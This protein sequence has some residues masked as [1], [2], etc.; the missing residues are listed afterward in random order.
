[1]QLQFFNFLVHTFTSIKIHTCPCLPHT[2]NCSKLRTQAV[3][4]TSKIMS[5][6]SHLHTYTPFYPHCHYCIIQLIFFSLYHVLCTRPYKL[7]HGK[8]TRPDQYQVRCERFHGFHV[9]QATLPNS[10]CLTLL[11]LSFPY[12]VEIFKC[13][14]F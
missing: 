7:K 4:L 9:A 12:K 8:M 1:M 11:T 10:R 14:F 2:P 5:S 3:E 13:G 6:N